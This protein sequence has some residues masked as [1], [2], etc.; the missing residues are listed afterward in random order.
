MNLFSIWIFYDQ[1]CAYFN[2]SVYVLD[3]NLSRL[4]S[5]VYKYSQIATALNTIRLLADKVTRTVHT[6]SDSIV[7]LNNLNLEKAKS[8]PFSSAV[9]S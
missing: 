1:S 7:Y 9:I 3:L 8:T 5:A 4:Y 6:I 2:L